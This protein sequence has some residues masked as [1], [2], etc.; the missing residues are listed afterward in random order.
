VPIVH[1]A[2]RRFEHFD[3]D[4]GKG[5]GKR[6]H[7]AHLRAMSTG[8]LAAGALTDRAKCERQVWSD[9]SAAGSVGEGSVPQVRAEAKRSAVLR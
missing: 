3:F 5:S 7:V 8:L 9:R 1:S 4:Q 2:E 6:R